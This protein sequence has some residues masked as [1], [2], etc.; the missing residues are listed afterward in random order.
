MFDVG[1]DYVPPWPQAD[2]PHYSKPVPERG[3]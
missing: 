3:R 1:S 2:V